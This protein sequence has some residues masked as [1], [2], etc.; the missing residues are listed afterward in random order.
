MSS[1]TRSFLRRKLDI[2]GGP[3]SERDRRQGGGKFTR[4]AP[5]V[6]KVRR[7]RSN[8]VARLARKVNR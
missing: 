8:A 7:R 1:Y 3:A 5:A 6:R 2:G 4:T